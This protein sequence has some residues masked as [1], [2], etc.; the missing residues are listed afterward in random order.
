M[1]VD[2]EPPSLI[3]SKLNTVNQL[4]RQAEASNAV[5]QSKFTFITGRIT[6]WLAHK[7][8][9]I[10]KWAQH[11]LSITKQ[12]ELAVKELKTLHQAQVSRS[13][14][15]NIKTPAQLE[16]AIQEASA[17]EDII[18]QQTLQAL[19]QSQQLVSR[20][21]QKVGYGHLTSA[22]TLLNDKAYADETHL[23]EKQNASSD[24]SKSQSQREWHVNLGL[25]MN[26]YNRTTDP[27]MKKQVSFLALNYLAKTA[28]INIR[29]MISDPAS[30]AKLE[31]LFQLG[32]FQMMGSYHREVSTFEKYVVQEVKQTLPSNTLPES[33]ALT[34]TTEMAPLLL[35]KFPV[36]KT[37]TTDDKQLVDDWTQDL[38]QAMN[39]HLAKDDLSKELDPP[40]L[41]DLTKFLGKDFKTEGKDAKN[42]LFNDKFAHYESLI[43]QAVSRAVEQ[44][45]LQN[46]KIG[47]SPEEEKKLQEFIRAN[48]MAVCTTEIKGVGIISTLPLFDDPSFSIRRKDFSSFLGE[49]VNQTGIRLGGVRGREQIFNFIDF[50][51]LI[52]L[53]RQEQELTFEPGQL[54][55]FQ[56]VEY[57]GLGP[58]TLYFSDKKEITQTAL[59]KRF[60]ESFGP[61]SL[62]NPPSHSKILGQ[63]TC[64]LIKGLLEN[65]ADEKWLE[66]NANA[67]T[68]QL[69]QTSLFRLLLHLADADNRQND[70]T[71]FTQAIELIH[72]EI[73]T[74]LALT[75]PFK[76]EE[77]S[78]IYQ[79]QLSFIPKVLKNFVKAGI[80][81]SAMNTFAGINA[82]IKS[83]QPDLQRVYG[84]NSYFETV[85]F[86]GAN[87]SVAEVIENPAIQHVDLY[88]GEFN[89]NINTNQEHNEYV[90]GDIQGE[91]ESLL[92]AKP[93]TEHLTVAVDC[94]IDYIHSNKVEALLK[95]FSLQIQAGK[96]NFVFF[97]SGQK[98]D[99][100]GMDNYYGSNFYMINNGS[101]H[102]KGF[103]DL[104]KHD[105]YKTDPLSVQWF[106]LVNK[107][108]PQATDAYRRQIFDNTR[109]IL[110]QVPLSLKPGNNP[111]VKVCTVSQEMDPCF[112][113]IKLLS[114]K[115]ATSEIESM[116]YQR[117]IDQQAKIHFRG[118]FGF[119]HTN[120][121]FIPDQDGRVNIRINPGL[122][123]DEVKLII[124]FLK[125]LADRIEK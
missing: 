106:C 57:Q 75:S 118:S 11:H 29:E 45:K 112:I 56:M 37:E 69:V 17:Q 67:D 116:L 65:I 98:F 95:H 89:H 123:P 34:D 108:A 50:A 70:F 102:W 93:K 2:R 30:A 52:E 99:M 26:V 19:Q 68:R 54:P 18:P 85:G 97:R 60:E 21:A 92:K 5:V 13:S 58:N 87:R 43:D 72:C 124:D 86:I 78:K 115:L 109:E 53:T 110:N 119:Y 79:K 82:T 28:P 101:D 49:F 104:L 74:L 9:K 22:Q 42:Q 39:Q 107:C 36:L 55:N 61:D 25:L 94:T 27:E 24:V 76:E 44:I 47:Q 38:T 111:H 121:N 32:F 10:P 105:A 64:Q 122:N 1:N 12:L 91:V 3:Q 96:L 4:T 114:P 15:E 73:A 20:L 16:E 23:L 83:Q 117:F 7:Q 59:F 100:L 125:E 66:L 62:A 41:L 40:L 51:T 88:V 35:A 46:P 31:D 120:V 113:D 6:C 80:S 8:G 77:F 90:V 81:K 63:S 103:N 71:K 84:S 33:F 48:I 14:L